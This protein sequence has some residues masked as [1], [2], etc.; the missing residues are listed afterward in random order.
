M[1]KVGANV[2]LIE[3]D[4]ALH[5]FW[6]FLIKKIHPNSA[7]SVTTNAEDAERLISN[8]LESP[9]PFDL[10]IS[11]LFL[12]GEMTGLELWKLF[13][14]SEILFPQFIIV[15]S[16]PIT[17]YERLVSDEKRKPFFVRKPLDP[18]FCGN[19]ISKT[20]FE[21]FQRTQMQENLKGRTIT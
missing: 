12:K 2:L 13:S 21:I 19:L 9:S 14:E 4:V 3:D 18:N 1:S 16:V 6:S 5:Q 15:S 8:A 17:E 20:F 7:I 10:V 11:N